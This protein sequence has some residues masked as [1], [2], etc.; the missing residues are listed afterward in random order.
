MPSR[1]RRWAPLVALGLVAIGASGTAG[2]LTVEAVVPGGTRT[3][4]VASLSGGD[5]DTL[6]LGATGT[7]GFVANVTDLAYDRAGYQVTASM[8]G[9]YAVS[10]SGYDCERAIPS[11]ALSLSFL[12][13]PVSVSDL[14]ALAQPL[15][16]L[17]GSLEATLATT[18]GVAG[19]TLVSAA[20][21]AGEQVSGTLAGAYAGIEDVLPVQ[22]A[23]G[24]GG[25][26][27]D[28]A[29]HEGCDPAPGA[30][31][32]SRLVMSGE[33]SDLGALFAWLAGEIT[34]A[35][36]AGGDATVSADE[37]VSTGT[38]TD[39]TMAAAVRA[40]LDAAGVSLALLD[41]LVSAGTVTMT[42]IY[43]SL[44]AT[45]DPITSLLGQSGTYLAMPALGID[46][47]EDA[48]PGTY[49]GTL[50][51]TLVDVA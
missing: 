9:L 44:E 2:P 24:A 38:V 37:L 6:S 42:E 27:D 25:A 4:T 51:L 40:A 50:T 33:T 16:D 32:T 5:L 49:R 18:L 41:A 34:S 15:W 10:G 3:L 23:S 45:L 26:F 30:A 43:A 8:S 29:P 12:V 7:A 17:V 11:S 39:E 36:D 28:P 13:S 22:V 35:A 31:P 48:A 19:G 20:D 46:L 47:P 1:G 14:A 21:V